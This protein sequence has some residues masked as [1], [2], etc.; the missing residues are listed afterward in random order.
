MLIS[1]L[2]VIKL[3]RSLL[4]VTNISEVNDI[5]GPRQVMLIIRNMNNLT[6]YIKGV[7]YTVNY[8]I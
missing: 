2:S 7:K 6:L 1:Y 5:Y 4:G 8:G 3:A